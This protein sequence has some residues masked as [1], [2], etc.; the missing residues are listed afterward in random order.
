MSWSPPLAPRSRFGVSCSRDESAQQELVALRS[1]LLDAL[2]TAT[3]LQDTSQSA[4]NQQASSLSLVTAD[5]TQLDL[6]GQLKALSLVHGI[7][8]HSSRV[9][10]GPG[11]G[12]TAGSTVSSLLDSTALLTSSAVPTAAPNATVSIVSAAVGALGVAL[13]WPNAA[14]A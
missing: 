8:D 2:A 1:N 14:R 9:G 13:A 12:E 10:L 4:L 5:V 11:T 6:E 3:E 7:A